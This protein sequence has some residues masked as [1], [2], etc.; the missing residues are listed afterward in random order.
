MTETVLLP[1]LLTVIAGL[2]GA[3]ASVL[4]TRHKSSG[5]IGT[6]DAEALWVEGAQMRKELRAEIVTLR[7]DLSILQADLA[8]AR[9]QMAQ[10]SGEAEEL[11]EENR[12]LRAEIDMLRE[13]R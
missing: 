4:I 2:A 11:R 5:K 7:S 3:A 9:L 10:L 1:L 8:A 12:L 13:P 6:S